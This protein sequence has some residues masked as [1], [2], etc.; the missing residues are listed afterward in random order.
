MTFTSI[1]FIVQVFLMVVLIL[2]IRKTKFIRIIPTQA[3][4]VALILSLI[5]I[6]GIIMFIGGCIGMTIYEE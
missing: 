1:L 3:Q 4:V 2:F 6:L 5:P